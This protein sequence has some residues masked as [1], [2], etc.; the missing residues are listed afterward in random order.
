[1]RYCF[2]ILLACL[3]TCS[4]SGETETGEFSRVEAVQLSEADHRA[5]RRAIY[6]YDKT[7]GLRILF[8]EDWGMEKER[9]E[10]KITVDDVSDDQGPLAYWVVKEDGRWRVTSRE[11]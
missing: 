8:T 11:L 7:A 10:Y 3:A 2:F 1:M 5:I 4:C 6:E 9:R